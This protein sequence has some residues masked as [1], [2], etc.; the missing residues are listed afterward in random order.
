MK[1]KY[2]EILK[3]KAIESIEAIKNDRNQLD[4]STKEFEE[5][6]NTKM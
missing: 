4:Y 1:I 6:K 2:Y 3:E 5:L